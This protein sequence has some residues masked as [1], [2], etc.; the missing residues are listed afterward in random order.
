MAAILF[1]VIHME[2]YKFHISQQKKCHMW[3]KWNRNNDIRR[4]KTNPI[5]LSVFINFS[6]F[7]EIFRPHSAIMS[8]CV[9]ITNINEN[10]TAITSEFKHLTERKASICSSQSGKYWSVYV[11][12]INWQEFKFACIFFLYPPTMNMQISSIISDCVRAWFE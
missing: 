8:V 1:P 10:C 2:W 7:S 4:Y 5:S 9:N 12:N 6:L 11:N 3:P